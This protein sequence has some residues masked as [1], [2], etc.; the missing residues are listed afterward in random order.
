MIHSG[1]HV[2]SAWVQMK[3]FQQWLIAPAAIGLIGPLQVNANEIN[4][5]DIADY[6]SSSTEISTSQFSDV[7]PGDWA[8]TALEKLSERQGC[9]DQSIESGQPLTRYEAAALINLCLEGGIASS[10]SNA[11]RLSNEF[12][13][14]MAI[15]KG[16][17]DGLEYKIEELRA[18]AFSSA[19]KMSGGSVFTTGFVDNAATA[20][21]KLTVEYNY[22][23][24]L[25]SSF[26]GMD[27]LY[28]GLEAGNQNQLVMD[29]SVT[30]G[31]GLQVASLYY[32]FPVGNFT[33]TAGPRFDQDDVISATTSIYSSAFRLGEMPWGTAGDTGAGVGV[34]YVADNGWNGSVNLLTQDGSAEVSTIGLFTEEATDMYTASI[35]YDGGNWGGGV[36]ATTEDQTATDT[37]DKSLGAGV[38]FRPDGFPSISMAFDRLDNE[39]GTNSRDFM[40]GVDH[41]LGSGVLSAAYQA[42][43]N[44]GTNTA[45]Y[46]V[47]Y[48][49]PIN[50]GVSVQ[51][52]IFSQEQA[53][54]DNTQGFIVETFFK[55]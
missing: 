25:N 53:A 54:V 6:A 19:T 30:G 17:I 22:T 12:G 52:G 55:F 23:I 8:Y 21:N 1:E 48:N 45:N 26:T 10:D 16:R 39:D 37:K 11:I 42:R 29:S 43:D 35:G 41:G 46:E 34:S 4:I 3:S 2:Q 32:E 31:N 36:V 5:N 9:I 24:D 40:I 13:T 28:A 38:Y 44:Q 14:E 7:F 18:G 47:Y 33:V 50:D 15:L 51:G 49:Y 27:N 20:D